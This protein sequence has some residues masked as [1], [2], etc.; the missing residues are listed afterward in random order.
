MVPPEKFGEGIYFPTSD[1]NTGFSILYFNPDQEPI[2]VT[3]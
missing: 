3:L 2:T 1:K